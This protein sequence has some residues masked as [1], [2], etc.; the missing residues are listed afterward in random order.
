MGQNDTHT[1]LGQNPISLSDAEIVEASLFFFARFLVL[2]QEHLDVQADFT[3][4]TLRL[5]PICTHTKTFKTMTLS[6]SLAPRP[7]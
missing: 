4:N 1:R 6:G 3:W 5:V 7:V 2:R